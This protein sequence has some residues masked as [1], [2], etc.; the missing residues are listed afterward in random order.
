MAKAKTEDTEERL[1]VRFVGLPGP[2]ARLEA[3]EVVIEAGSEGRLP[4]T[5]A[6]ELAGD[7]NLGIELLDEEA[8]AA[9][10]PTGD[11]PGVEAHVNPVDAPEEE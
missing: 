7:P 1:R 2:P 9:E 11:L 5:L 8:P 3:G 4:A 10:A 6:R